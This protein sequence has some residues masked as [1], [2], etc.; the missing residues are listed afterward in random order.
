ML[1]GAYCTASIEELPFEKTTATADREHIMQGARVFLDSEHLL[2]V[3]VLMLAGLVLAEQ[4]WFSIQPLLLAAHMR[5]FEV[6]LSYALGAVGSV[7]GA[8][9]GK[10]LLT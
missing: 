3:S 5:P 6:G 9:V 4:L 8:R 7:L 2:H 10:E 1:I